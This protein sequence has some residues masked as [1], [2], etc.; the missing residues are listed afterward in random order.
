[1]QHPRISEHAV[2]PRW[3]AA[4]FQ[5]LRLQSATAV[6]YDQNPTVLLG[7]SG[8]RRGWNP[9]YGVPDSDGT[10]DRPERLAAG[11]TG[12]ERFATRITVQAGY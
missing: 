6:L 3:T 5:G 8:E 4:V 11:W 7:R 1:M 12:A 10:H 9:G 2:Q